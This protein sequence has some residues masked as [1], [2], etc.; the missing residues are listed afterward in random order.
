MKMKEVVRPAYDKIHKTIARI[1]SKGY[2]EY[3]QKTSFNDDDWRDWIGPAEAFEQIGKWQFDRMKG[4]GLK[5]Q[6][7]FLDLGCGVLRGGIHFIEYL[8]K[9]NYTGMDVN[10]KVLR[11]GK[12][13]IKEHDLEHKKPTVINNSDLK[14]SEIEERQD[15]V[16]AVS[17]FTHLKRKHIEEC[18][19]NIES[20]LKPNG[21][22]LFTYNK[23]IS[24]EPPGF[25]DYTFSHTNNFFEQL[26]K[27]NG[28]TGRQ[29]FSGHPKGQELYE[30]RR[31]IR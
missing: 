24:D 19:S 21:F 22:F 27:E 30:V 5:T 6:H 13:R 16:L 3:Y 25:L 28:L 1:S 7:K 14:F 29:V 26:I 23:T 17:V 2:M 12:E 8:D 10:K 18:F 20:I 15:Y 4:H 11:K 31:P 9:G